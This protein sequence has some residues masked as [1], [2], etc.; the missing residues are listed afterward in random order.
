VGSLVHSLSVADAEP[1]LWLFW[2]D[3]ELCDDYCCLCIY[4]LCI[5]MLSLC[6]NCA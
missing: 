6:D 4:C 5:I 3:K 2:R 1:S